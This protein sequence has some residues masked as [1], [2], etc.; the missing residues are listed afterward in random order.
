MPSDIAIVAAALIGLPTA[1]VALSILWAQR[2]RAVHASSSLRLGRKEDQLLAD[3][4]KLGKELSSIS[5]QLTT[6]NRR[7]REGND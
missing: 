6:L 2:D 4:Q 5:N 7:Q 1:G 3:V